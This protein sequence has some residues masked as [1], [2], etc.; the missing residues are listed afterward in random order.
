MEVRTVVHGVSVTERNQCVH[1]RSDRDIVAIRFKC[2]DTFYACILCH[3]EIAG[4][5]PAVWGRDEREVRA[6]LCGACHGTLSIAEYL[7]S[8]NTCPRCGAAFNPR[9]G[10]HYHLY[11]EV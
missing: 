6:I 5:E 8:G 7:A 4:H 2:C 1:Y 11:F 9:C 10:N 3:Q